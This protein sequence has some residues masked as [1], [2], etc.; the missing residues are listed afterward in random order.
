MYRI[1]RLRHGESTRIGDR[2]AI[3]V[4][5]QSVAKQGKAKAQWSK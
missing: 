4:A 3:K 1:V 2:D 5:M